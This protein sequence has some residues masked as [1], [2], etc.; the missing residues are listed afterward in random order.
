MVKLADGTRRKMTPVEKDRYQ[1]AT[2]AAYRQFITEQGANLLRMEP[3]L[4][5][6]TISKVTERLRNQ[7]AYQAVRR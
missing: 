4:A 1:R 3:E 7:A 6:E 5:R 2:G